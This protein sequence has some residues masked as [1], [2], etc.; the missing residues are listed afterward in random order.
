MGTHYISWMVREE[1]QMESRLLIFRSL[2]MY[3][4][5][6]LAATA[7]EAGTAEEYLSVPLPEP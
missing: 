5:P 7:A 3:L 1:Q 4:W 2:N 6:G